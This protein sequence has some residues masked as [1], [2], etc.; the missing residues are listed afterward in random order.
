[1]LVLRDVTERKRAEGERVRMLR[2]QAARAEAEAGMLRERAGR[3]E[4]EAANR[5]KDRFLATLSHE[6]RT[7]LTPILATATAMLDD[8]ATPG[9]FRSVLEMIRRNVTL[10]ARL[11]DDLLDLTRIRGGKLH[12]ER[13]V[14]DAHELVHHVVE[15]CQEDLRSKRPATGVGSRGPAAPR[16]CRSGPF[17]AGP[18]EP[19]QERDQ[20]H[21][22][23]RDRDGPV[24]RRGWVAPGGDGHELDPRG[25]RH[26]YR[27][28]DRHAAPDLRDLRAGGPARRRSDPGA[29]GWA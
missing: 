29:W 28:R 16:G 8:P 9:P 7:P 17:A 22:P 11:I 3:A 23:R 19:A 12:L 14:I 21:T 27:H 1:M 24:S 26:G 25:Q 13:G 6:L 15:I 2:E 20:V 4:A 18:L 10:E 5:A